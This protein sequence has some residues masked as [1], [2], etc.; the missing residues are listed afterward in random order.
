MP[1]ARKSV[2]SLHYGEGSRTGEQRP[3][4]KRQRALR[5]KRP[6]LSLMTGRRRRAPTANGPRYGKSSSHV[7]FE[8]AT[9]CCVSREG[10]SQCTR[11]INVFLS[12]G[13]LSRRL[14]DAIIYSIDELLPDGTSWHDVARN[15]R[16]VLL[17]GS[18]DNIYDFVKPLRAKR[19]LS[20]K[21][22]ESATK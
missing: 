8:N 21:V 16:P 22:R 3:L 15:D 12:V 19:T 20:E 17:C 4:R 1:A 13:Y 10:E 6:C 14:K 11:D 5:V 7:I 9:T 2:V 18:I